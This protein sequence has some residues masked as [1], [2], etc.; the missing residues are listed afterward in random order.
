MIGIVAAIAYGILAIAGGI[1]GY[2][3]AQSLPSLISG[4]VSGG[5]LVA[6]GVGQAQGQGWGWML[7]TGV[8]IALIMVFTLRLWKTQKV[9]PAGLMLGAGIAALLGLLLG[10]TL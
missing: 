10:G 5:L 8:T 3:K 2:V 1:F 9:M 6:G 4:V 7:S